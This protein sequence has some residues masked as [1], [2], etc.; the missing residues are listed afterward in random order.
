MALHAAVLDDRIGQVTTIGSIVAY[1]EFVDRPISR[2]M[3]EVNLPGVLR[4]YDLPDLMEVLGDRLI[5]VNPANAIGEPLSAVEAAQVAPAA[6]VVTTFIED[7]FYRGLQQGKN[8]PWIKYERPPFAMSE[9]ADFVWHRYFTDVQAQNR[10][11]REGVPEDVR[12]ERA[13]RKLKAMDEYLKREGRAHLI[14]ISPTRKEVLGLQ[15][16]DAKVKAAL[17]RHGV[18]AIYLLDKPRIVGASQEEKRDW[19]MDN[20]HL[21]PKGHAVWGELMGQ[22]LRRVERK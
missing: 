8:K 19:Y 10:R 9:L 4:R 17:E 15:P 7:D 1:R 21:T 16:R 5:L 3:A 11:E 22:E 12:V 13:A 2:D 14:F 20:D 6:T 18:A